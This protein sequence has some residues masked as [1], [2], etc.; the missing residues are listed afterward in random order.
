MI[1]F[2]R[3]LFVSFLSTIVFLA[4]CI[5][6]GDVLLAAIVAIATVT[7]QLVLG[8]TVR[9]SRGGMTWASLAV[10]LTLTGTTL[11]GDNDPANSAS[12]ISNQNF[13]P[14]DAICRPASRDI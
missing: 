14:V 4:S 1:Y 12:W 10:V 9:G 3:R 13:M 5:V 8:W 6:E 7:A 11:A 2:F